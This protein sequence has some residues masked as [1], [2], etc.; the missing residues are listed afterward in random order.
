[1][2]ITLWRILPVLLMGV[3]LFVASAR[4]DT[5]YTYTGNPFTDCLGI[6]HCNGTTPFLSIT[7]DTTLTGPALDNL[8]L[9]DISGTIHPSQSVIKSTQVLQI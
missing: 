6:Y 1:M 5:V 3:Y 4:A 8:N 7:F 2:K 9:A